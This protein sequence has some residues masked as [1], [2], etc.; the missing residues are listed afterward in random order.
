MRKA[1]CLWHKY[2][3]TLKESVTIYHVK[4]SKFILENI[5]NIDTSMIVLKILYILD[6]LFID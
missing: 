4:T 2:T 1:V 3:S 5:P 6:Y